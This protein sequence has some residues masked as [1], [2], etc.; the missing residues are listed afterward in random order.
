MRTEQE[1]AAELDT[2]DRLDMTSVDYDAQEG[3]L[4]DAFRVALRWA[5]GDRATPETALIHPGRPARD[6][7]DDPDENS[8]VDALW[9]LMEIE[10]DD[11]AGPVVRD[12]I[13][14][15]PEAART[16]VAANARR[17]DRLCKAVRKA[18]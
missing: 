7:S 12:M 18:S 1:I 11:V 9:I 3:A 4:R 6:F 17:I 16:N 2:L 5:L 13:E 14:A 15:L 8:L 10:A